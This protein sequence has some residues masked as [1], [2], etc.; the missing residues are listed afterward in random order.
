MATI[1]ILTKVCFVPP[2]VEHGL[3]NLGGVFWVW[4]YGIRIYSDQIYS[5]YDNISV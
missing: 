4:S 3:S 5:N 2:F 1:I